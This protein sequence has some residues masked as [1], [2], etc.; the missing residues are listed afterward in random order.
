MT[1]IVLDIATA[2][3]ADA[4]AY[5]DGAIKAPSNYKDEAKIAEY[6]REKEAERLEKA[7]TD[8][9][10]ARITAVGL[11]DLADLEA[12]G[13]WTCVT[14]ADERTVLQRL[15]AIIRSDYDTSLITYGGLRF[16]LPMIARRAR[17]LGVSFPPLNVDKY[18]S[19]HRDLCD[20]LSD[21]DPSRMRSLGF[22]AKRLG[23][24]DVTKPL[25]GAEEARVPETGRW[26]DLIAAVAHD[27]TQTAR[28]AIWLGV[29]EPHEV[30]VLGQAVR[31]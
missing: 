24:T 23:W 20:I 13:I 28:L 12:S 6:I 30:P 2:P 8:L 29:L 26:D 11:Y 14:E 25:S 9:D 16:D 5:I 3:I 22:Y 15:A 1:Q 4:A 31:A 10:L 27:L 19:P 17:Y 7:A 18:R 21:R